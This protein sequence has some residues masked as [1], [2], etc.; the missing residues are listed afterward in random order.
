MI[1]QQRPASLAGC[2]LQHL[3]PRGRATVQLRTCRHQPGWGCCGE[4]CVLGA[5]HHGVQGKVASS[6]P[7]ELQ[8]DTFVWKHMAGNPVPDGYFLPLPRLPVGLCSS[9]THS[10][11]VL[12]GMARLPWS[13]ALKPPVGPGRVLVSQ[14][15]SL[16]QP[17]R[18]TPW[19]PS[20][21]ARAPVQQAGR[22]L[23]M[24][25]TG[26]WLKARFRRS[27]SS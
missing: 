8:A 11:A 25:R 3:S 7:A 24:R 2:S 9:R 22:G 26:V 20:R 18:N 5:G 6:P 12:S 14:L 1:F 10:W 4:E 23:C 19:S 16:L 15:T 13:T 21:A 17:C 27:K